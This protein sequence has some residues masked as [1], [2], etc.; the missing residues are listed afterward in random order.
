[1]SREL[2][3]QGIKTIIIAGQSEGDI[4]TG[5]NIIFVKPLVKSGFAGNLLFLFQVAVVMIQTLRK[6]G[7]NKIIIR[8]SM[9][10]PLYIILK[11]L[12]KHLIYD[13]HGYGYK[14]LLVH[15]R[16]H[17]ARVIRV[18]EWLALKSVNH[19]LA[20]REELKQSLPKRFQRK[21][22]LMPNGVDLGEFAGPVDDGILDRYSIPQNKK[23]VGYNGNWEA[24]VDIEDFLESVKYFEDD[25][26]VVVAGTGKYLDEYKRRYPSILF[27][28]NIPF[29]DAIG[30]LKKMNICVLP[31]SNEPIAKNKS[32]R[33]IYEYMAAG[34]PIVISDADSREKFL[35]D[36]ENVLMYRAGDSEDLAAK[37]KL[38]LNNEG[39]RG[40][41]SRNNLELAK[42]F[43]WEKVVARSGLIEL[44]Q[45]S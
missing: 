25:V 42:Q 4:I 36:G 19:I 17:S 44:L 41:M 14:E 34:K 24:W 15:G 26:K 11:L 2:N 29:R 33:K 28:G 27:T 9:L 22:L 32:Y 8:S 43:T 45:R 35:K 6:T 23:L 20:I 30:I 16:K 39:L 37:V 10:S 31:Y 12:G 7:I 13:F 1:M 38:L 40:K 3:E 18:F 21:T 5:K